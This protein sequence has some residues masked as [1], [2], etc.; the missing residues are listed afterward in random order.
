[1]NGL[2][3]VAEYIIAQLEDAVGV[4]QLEDAVGGRSR[5][6]QLDNVVGG[7]SWRTQLIVPRKNIEII[8]I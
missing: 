5:R 8:F 6:K 4:T 1:M 2:E 3:E 7:H